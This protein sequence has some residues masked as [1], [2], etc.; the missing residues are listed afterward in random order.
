MDRRSGTLL[1]PCAGLLF[2][3]ITSA[4]IA[5]QDDGLAAARTAIEAALR[6]YFD[7]PRSD[8]SELK[9]VLAAAKG[10]GDLLAQVVKSKSFLAPSPSVARRGR[11]ELRDGA[12]RFVELAPGADAA[13]KPDPR[14]GFEDVISPDEPALFF[15]PATS[16]PLHPLVV[17]VPDLGKSAMFEPE[18]AAQA[19][20]GR[21]VLL[22]PDDKGDNRWDPTQAE[23]R[24]HVGPLRDLLLH[25]AIDPDRV[26]MVG[27]GRGGH[28]TWDVGLLHCDRFAG[29]FPCN[30]TPFHEGGWKASGGVFL[31]NAKCLPIFAVWNT[32][33]D[34]GIE[35]CR[36]AA[37]RFKEWGFRFEPKEETEFRTMQVA[38]AMVKLDPLVRD[39]HPHDVVKRFNHLDAGG[40]VWLQALRRVPKEWDPKAVITLRSQP[41]DA[42]KMREAIWE[43]VQRECARLEG[44]IASNRIT[45]K[46]QGIGRLRVWFD[47]ELLDER[48]KVAVTING[49]AQPPFTL[50]RS[51]AVMLQRVHETGDTARL[52]WGFRDFDTAN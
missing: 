16:G 10:R 13:P 24:R 38:E 43:E 29:L 25:F 52:Y 18:L 6:R 51:P 15:G 40:H 47:S 22:V 28:A 9:E 2:A 48:S 1:V 11:I 12:A 39:A 31:E 26:F 30:G 42:T 23:Q 45:I 46:T 20:Q 44:S 17:Y 4:A 36:Y 33:F 41:D 32:T 3:A 49:K 35:G 21:F 27:S 8:G 14:P 37:R 5:G 50:E 19:A 7:A 34:H